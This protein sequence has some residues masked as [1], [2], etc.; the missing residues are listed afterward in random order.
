M[1]FRHLILFA[2]PFVAAT[3]AFAQDTQ[4]LS[5]D[6]GAVAT[7]SP[8]G[9][10]VTIGA[11]AIYLPDYEGS[12]DYHLTSAPGAIGSIDG[13]NF[14]LA[15]NRLSVDLIPN[16]PGPSWD[17]QAGPLAVLNIN[18]SSLKGIA[19]PRIRALGKRSMALELGGYVGI[20][21]TG[22]I[23]SEYDQLSF[24]I[25]YRKGVT[26]AH[27]GGILSPTINY[28]TPLSR[29]AAVGLY[30]SAER[31]ERKYAAAYFDVD[32]AGSL[33]SGLPT[34]STRG[35]WKNYTV[36]ALGTVSLTGDLLHG[37]KLV[38]GG[39]YTRLLNDFGYSPVVRI[40]GEKSQWMGV[41]GLAY[42]F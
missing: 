12:N 2:A 29:K 35:G 28:F 3:P 14:T 16:R 10:S 20:G 26:G 17:F 27:S 40:A 21:K 42:T 1:R 22:V 19:D 25:S 23:T 18:R 41:L 11:A 24:S 39:T 37:F 33:A 6:T 38:G 4:P 34:F 32:A 31:A 9:D 5:P 8:N 30:V 36:G 7:A 13:F 15:A